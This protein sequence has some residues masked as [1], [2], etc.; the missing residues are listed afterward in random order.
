MDSKGDVEINRSQYRR[1]R[2]YFTLANGLIVIG[3]LTAASV[4]GYVALNKMGYF[5]TGNG[6]SGP[7]GN[8]PSSDLRHESSFNPGN[9]EYPGG[10]WNSRTDNTLL[11]AHSCSGWVSSSENITNHG[12]RD[13]F[14]SVTEQP[15]E[16]ARNVAQPELLVPGGGSSLTDNFEPEE[17]SEIERVL[18]SESLLNQELS[19]ARI[20]SSAETE[21]TQELSRNEL[22]SSFENV[23]IEELVPSGDASL[24]NDFELEESSANELVSS[25]G[26]A[27][28]GSLETAQSNEPFASE[29]EESP[30]VL[31]ADMSNSYPANLNTLLPSIEPLD[32]QQAQFSSHVPDS[33]IDSIEVSQDLTNS[34]PD[35]NSEVYVSNELLFS[36]K[37]NVLRIDLNAPEFKVDHITTTQ[38]RDSAPQ[39]S[40]DKKR[41][42]YT[43]TNNIEVYDVESKQFTGITEASLPYIYTKGKF[44]LLKPF[45]NEVIYVSRVGSEYEISYYNISN[46]EQTKP[47]GPHKCG[48]RKSIEILGQ[49]SDGSMLL[50][51]CS[52]RDNNVYLKNLNNH[53]AEDL[54]IFEIDNSMTRIS[55]S[56]DNRIIISCSP[57]SEHC[58]LFNISDPFDVTKQEIPLPISTNVYNQI[59]FSNDLKTLFILGSDGMKDV[60]FDLIRLNYEE[61]L[62]SPGK[63]SYQIGETIKIPKPKNY[64]DTVR[65]VQLEDGHVQVIYD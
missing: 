49:I 13:N 15:Q 44:V 52:G 38:L 45:L 56:P 36:E 34:N 17:T 57:G 25:L 26:N 46:P 22:G 35:S 9:A 14:S 3:V 24:T 5:G 19:V 12:E 28:I 18:S 50:Y 16:F 2:T 59:A 55:I 20:N 51:K 7:Q 11:E 39:Y 48:S 47:I 29:L 27:P 32:I 54:A 64:Q 6:S 60:D 23:R 8:G 41:I 43:G 62:N 37:V 65:L 61:I 42:Y 1:K 4:M 10:R 30:N 33:E 31:E 40:P 53:E 58:S 63:A 21:Q